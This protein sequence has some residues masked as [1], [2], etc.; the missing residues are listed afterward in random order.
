[1]AAPPVE[2]REVAAELQVAQ[3][4]V[5]DPVARPVEARKAIT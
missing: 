5:V 1:M 3:E 4:S 2:T